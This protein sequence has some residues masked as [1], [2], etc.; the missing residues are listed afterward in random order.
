MDGIENPD[1]ETLV[2]C[3]PTMKSIDMEVAQI[4]ICAAGAQ[5][6]CEAPGLPMRNFIECQKDFA[7]MISP[8]DTVRITVEHIP[9]PEPESEMDL[10]DRDSM[11]QEEYDLTRPES[12]EDPES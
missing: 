10:D 2:E 1:T 5:L 8:R 7:R 6:T 4:V 9:P 3:I 12:E 11:L